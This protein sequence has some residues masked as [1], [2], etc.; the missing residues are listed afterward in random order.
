MI[1]VQDWGL[2]DYRQAEKRQLELLE[3]VA[4]GDSPDTLVVCQHP[5]VVTTGRGTQTGDVFAW[6]GDTIEVGRGG[7]ATYHGPNQ[8]VVYPIVKLSAE[9][10]KGLKARDINDYLRMLERSLVNTLTELGVNAESREGPADATGVWVGEQKIA[11]I[12]IG[13]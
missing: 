4:S 2:I 6:T 5:P 9:N 3:K 13:V 7:R 8:I 11:S 10:R 1:E 12:G